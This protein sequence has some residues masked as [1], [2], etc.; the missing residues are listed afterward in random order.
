MA[1]KQ[2]LTHVLLVVFLDVRRGWVKLS[3]ESGSRR[4]MYFS[5]SFTCK[6][7]MIDYDSPIFSS[8]DCVIRCNDTIWI[9]LGY[10]DITGI[11]RYSMY[12]I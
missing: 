1:I 10:F 9:Y 5:L 12:S 11:D 8:T 7:K 6:C 3:R 4:P 2:I